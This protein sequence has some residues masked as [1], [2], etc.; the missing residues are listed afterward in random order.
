M[1]DAFGFELPAFKPDEALQTLRRALQAVGL[2]ERDGRFERRGTVIARVALDGDAL[3]AGRVKR[4]SRSS[5]EWLD[6]TLKSSSDV[7]N[8]LAD[9]QKQLALW[10]DSD[11]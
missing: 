9:L 11:G 6:K 3:R 1:S 4:P 5:P 8:F 10:T 2:T 7:R